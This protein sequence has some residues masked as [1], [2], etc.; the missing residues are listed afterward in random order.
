[1][2]LQKVN[3]QNNQSFVSLM[4]INLFCLFTLSFFSID[5]MTYECQDA[6]KISS[7]FVVMTLEQAMTFT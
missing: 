6:S 5:L 4:S 1:M 7:L 3:A 2:Q